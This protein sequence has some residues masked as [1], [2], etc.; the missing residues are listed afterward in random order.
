MLVRV[1]DQQE[2]TRLAYGG[3][4]KCELVCRTGLLSTR[5]FMALVLTLA[6]VTASCDDLLHSE[7]H[8]QHTG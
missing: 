6:P 4:G 1:E 2:D 8:L 7:Q 5:A 3:D